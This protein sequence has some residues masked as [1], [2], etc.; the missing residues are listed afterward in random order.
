MKWFFWKNEIAQSNDTILG[1]FLFKQIY[2][3]F[4]YTGIFKTWLVV[5]ILRFQKLFD[6]DI[7]DF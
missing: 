7:L 6:E 5:N 4:T 1:Y 3:I 2:Y